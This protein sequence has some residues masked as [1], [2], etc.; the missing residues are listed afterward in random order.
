[1]ISPTQNTWSN[2][3]ATNNPVLQRTRTRRGFWLMGALVLIPAI[4]LPPRSLFYRLLIDTLNLKSLFP[5]S[6]S[7]RKLDFLPLAHL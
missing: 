1:M 2:Q 4:L 3:M 5:E 7:C 6:V